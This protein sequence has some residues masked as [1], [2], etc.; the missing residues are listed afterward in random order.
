[1]A[2]QHIDEPHEFVEVLAQAGTAQFTGLCTG[3]GTFSVTLERG[4]QGRLS[5]QP[6]CRHARP[7]AGRGAQGMQ[8]R[9]HVLEAGVGCEP[10]VLLGVI[11]QAGVQDVHHRI[12]ALIP[13]DVVV[14]RAWLLRAL[15]VGVVV[16]VQLEV[17]EG[18]LG[19]ERCV[20][21]R[22]LLHT[23]C[24]APHNALPA[25]VVLLGSLTGR[26]EIHFLHGFWIARLGALFLLSV[27]IHRTLA[28]QE[29][30][31]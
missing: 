22:V 15:C 2:A 25:R 31:E 10:I 12:V 21:F 16:Q 4:L 7:E 24:G 17:L 1:M 11:A 30:L 8:V 27:V 9:L 20:P 14:A 13:R 29:S 5:R 28:V 3:Y 26:P 19:G 23:N 6:G 18:R